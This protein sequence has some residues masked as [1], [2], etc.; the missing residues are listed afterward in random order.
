[1][2]G[3]LTL[4]NI[5]V[6]GGSDALDYDGTIVA[7]GDAQLDA[8]A[9]AN[10]I[11]L[12]AGADIDYIFAFD[13]A[14]QMATNKLFLNGSNGS[15]HDFALGWTFCDERG[16]FADNLDGAAGVPGCTDATAC[17]YNAAANEDDG[18]CAYA[19]E[20][21]DCAGA[22]L[23]DTDGDGVC[24]ELEVL[25]CTDSAACNYDAAATDDDGSCAQLDLCGVCGGDDSSCSGC[26]DPAYIEYDPYATIDDNSCTNLVVLGCTYANATNYNPLANDD[27]QSCEFD[28]VVANPCPAD[29]DGSVA[30]SDL[31][32]FLSQFGTI[33]E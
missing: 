33:C 4:S 28:T 29:G 13:A 21:Y 9:S 31:L 16:M 22:C 6:V 30:T 27:D 11:V 2:A 25:G 8:Y 15:G 32:S 18:S 1:L 19:E 24:D 26:T 5:K 17:N 3:D 20:Y 14:G 7:D 10:G 12:D 23:N